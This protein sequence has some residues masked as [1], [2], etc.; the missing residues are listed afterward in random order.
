MQYRVS[1]LGQRE[2]R[3]LGDVLTRLLKAKR[4]SQKGRYG[5]LSLAWRQVV[6]EVLGEECAGQTRVGS[7]SHGRVMVEV[8]G[9]VLL[10][11]LS[12]FLRQKLLERLRSHP[13]AEDVA[14]LRFRL[15]QQSG[16]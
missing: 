6:E 14:D 5:A 16:R 13:G 10:Q 9:P 11:E 1:V 15:G 7:F 3:R 4:F 2:P 8:E 12:S